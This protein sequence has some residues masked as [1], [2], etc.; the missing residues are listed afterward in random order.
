MPLLCNPDT[1]EFTIE[2]E[3]FT[4][5]PTWTRHPDWTPE[6]PLYV[7]PY[8]YGIETLGWDVLEF[9][10]RWIIDPDESDPDVGYYV[11]WRPTDEQRR[12]ILWWYAVDKNGRFMYRRGIL[13]RLKGWGK[14]PVA[15]VLAI[16]E[17]VGPCRFR[18]WRDPATEELT[19][20]Y[21][22]GLVPVTKQQ[23][24]SYVQIAGVSQDQTENTMTL[25]S[26]YM[27]KEFKAKFGIDANKTI[28]YATGTRRIKAVT[29]NPRT[30]EGN[31]PTYVIENET[32]H[33]LSSNEGHA[34]HRV[35][36][37]NVSKSKGGM[38]R[39][40][41]ITNAYEPGEESVAQKQRESWQAEQD[42]R[43]PKTRVLY[44]SIE[45][46]SDARVVPPII[47]ALTGEKMKDEDGNDL[48]PDDALLQQ[49]LST[50]IEAVRG[51]ATWL[52]VETIVATIMD[53][54]NS[55]N[56]SRRK[57]FNQV[58]GA[59][60]R[61]VDRAHI[62][63]AAD[64]EIVSWRRNTVDPLRVSWKKIDPKEPVVLFGDGS[65]ADDAT[66]LVLMSLRTGL[67]LTVGIWQKPSGA[68]GKGWRAPRGDVDARVAE[69]MDRFNVVAFLF[70]PSHTKDEV[71]STP[72]W[73]SLVDGWH[74]KYGDRLQY[75]STQAGDRVH[76]VRWDMTSPEKAKQFVQAT[77]V[78]REE[79]IQGGTYTHDSH[80]ALIR[81][82]ENAR[83]NI[84]N[85][86]GTAIMK[87]HRE[88]AR[89]IDLAVCFVGAAMLR[90]LVLNK[91]LEAAPVSEAWYAPVR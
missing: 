75:W 63:A 68:A 51:D 7:L 54:S 13:Q 20:L 74:Q 9:I 71:D 40:L 45:A 11:P 66:A 73:D 81:H 53:S 33:W 3:P 62:D 29:S 23:P 10:E 77:E 19:D 43:A 64:Q 46:P 48:R 47:N 34:M 5:G 50:V 14:D 72:Y 25:I 44:D 88:S 35:L 76:S 24:M 79:L 91:G 57:Y 27:T 78:V 89:K 80:P 30:L 16:V 42:G 85:K 18:C 86:W 17:F 36:D 59:E 82:L 69:L 56:D 8:H 28:I 90:R 84:A 37:G 12:F 15:A 22:P 6:D 60:D 2:V 32:H 58:V 65:L 87:E 4:I 83:V 31:R 1:G 38:A 21:R 41:A 26:A 49:Y 55:P 39:I 52:D 67:A 61:W 70:D